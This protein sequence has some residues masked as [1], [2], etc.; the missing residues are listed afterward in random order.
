L[1]AP[2]DT[3]APGLRERK[4]AR[5]RAEIQ[6]QALRLFTEKGYEAT[7]A[8]EI[9]AAAEV[10]ESTFFR[11]FPTKAD[12]ALTDDFDPLIAAAF[13]AQPPQASAIGALRAAFRAVFAPLSVAELEEQRVRM[14]LVLS[15]P[16]LRSAMIDQFAQAMDMIAGL[17]S[18][19]SGR[20]VGDLAVRTF[21]GAVVGASMSVIFA[22]ADE[23]GGDFA[24]LVDRALAQLE[25][26]LEL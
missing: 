12:V 21:A 25:Q 10:S 15:V 7:T 9:A 5:T 3:R 13:R 19:R 24:E 1:P 23:P 20:A 11:Y 16:E 22:L 6:R 17:A 2:P 14:E 18:E 8:E 26:G 4:K